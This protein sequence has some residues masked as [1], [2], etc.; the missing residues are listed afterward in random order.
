MRRR[1]KSPIWSNKNKDGEANK[2]SSSHIISRVLRESNFELNYWW[3]DR[4]RPPRTLLSWEKS[5]LTLRAYWDDPANEAK[6]LHN[7]QIGITAHG[8]NY[9]KTENV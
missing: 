6:S 5:N 7:W 3:A 4:T 9:N 1:G 2:S 8:N